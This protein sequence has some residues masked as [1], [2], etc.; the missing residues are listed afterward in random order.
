MKP[1]PDALLDRLAR[2]RVVAGF[3]IEN[4]SHAV[5]L[6]RALLAGGIDTIELTLRSSAAM[7]AVRR[8]AEEVP[9]ICLGVGTILTPEQV[10]EVKEAGAAFGV[11]PGLNSR[12]VKTAAE[13]GLPF[14]PGVCTP[15]ELEGAIALGCRFVKFFP[16]EASGGLKYLRSMAA[17]YQHLGIQYFP[18]GG[19]NAV[20]MLDYL[21]E[22]NV[23]TIGG[24][25]IVQSD[26]VANGDWAAFT[27]RAAEVVKTL[28]QG[29]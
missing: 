15:S 25:W 10:L 21:R 12:V 19:L 11:A 29:N 1:F 14:A 4:A 5:P 24:S 22:Q 17:P 20:N 28:N 3:T 26:L 6:C 27:Q 8:I 18:L 7:G 23:P 2:S 16:A 13:A 9:E